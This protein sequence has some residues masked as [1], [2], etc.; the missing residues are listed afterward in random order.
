MSCPVVHSQL[1][2]CIDKVRQSTT[3]EWQVEEA[4]SP[5]HSEDD[6]RTI[7][8]LERQIDLQQKHNY[9]DREYI[10]LGI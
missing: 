3:I 6:M 1:D 2:M 10:H 9:T 8:R 7:P 5:D 4:L